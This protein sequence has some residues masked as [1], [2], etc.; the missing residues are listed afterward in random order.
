MRR[1]KADPVHVGADAVVL[2]RDDVDVLAEELGPDDLVAS[3]V[4]DPAHLDRHAVRL[5]EAGEFRAHPKLDLAIERAVAV[6]K[7]YRRAVHIGHRAF[8]LGGNDV[9]ARRA[10][11]IAD[12]RM[13]GTLEQFLWRADLDDTAIIH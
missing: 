8:N 1:I 9:H 13:L 2:A 5:T 4:L 6:R 7:L 3:H 10:D 12:K 11:E